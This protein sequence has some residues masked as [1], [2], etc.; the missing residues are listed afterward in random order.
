MIVVASEISCFSLL[1]QMLHCSSSKSARHRQSKPESAN[2]KKR[3]LKEPKAKVFPK[4]ACRV[5]KRDRLTID[6]LPLND[7]TDNEEDSADEEYGY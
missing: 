1:F 7:A 4:Q 5:S 3:K 6:Y 2:T